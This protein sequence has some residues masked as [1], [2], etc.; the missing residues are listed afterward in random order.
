MALGTDHFV[1]ADLAANIPE[2]WTGKTNDFYRSKLVAAG[3]FTDRSDEVRFGGDILHVSNTAA[4]T[5][6]AKSAQTQVVLQDPADTQNDL[7]IDQH[8]HAAFM[9]EDKELAQVARSYNVM[10][11]KMKDAAYAVAKQLDTAITTLFSGF[12]TTAGATTTALS[13]ANILAAYSAYATNDAPLEEAAWILHPKTIWE[14]IQA[15]DKYTLIQN[16]GVSGVGPL[17]GQIGTLWGRPVLQS[18]NIQTI[19][20]AADYAGFFGNPDAIH[21]ATAALPGSK[22]DMQVR[23]QSEYR[24]EYLGILVVA[25]MLYGV[26]ENRDDAGVQ[27]ISAV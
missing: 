16:H 6:N 23:I 17:T 14:D 21:F 26:A 8:Y 3:F 4:F 2:I 25:D 5:A 27:I 24:L 12:S 10:E 7:T 19:N 11:T 15:L 20:T 22:D 9:I 13:D 1:A 18:T